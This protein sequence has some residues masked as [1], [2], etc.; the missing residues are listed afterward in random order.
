LQ[1]S[2]LA[3]LLGIEQP[4]L[5][6]QIVSLFHLPYFLGCV[7]LSAVMGPAGILLAD[8]MDTG[9]MSYAVSDILSPYSGHPGWIGLL[10]L[11]LVAFITFWLLYMIRFMRLRLARAGPQLIS[12]SPKTEMTRKIFGIVSKAWPQILVTAVLFGSTQIFLVLVTGTSSSNITSGYFGLGSPLS[13][14]IEL[15][16]YL[17]IGTFVWVYA[18]ALWGIHRFGKEPL[19]LKPFYQDPLLGLGEMGTLSLYLA[20]AYYTVFGPVMFESLFLSPDP[21]GYATLIPFVVLGGIMF[22]LPLN[23]IHQKMVKV[24][25]RETENIEQK[26]ADILTILHNPAHIPDG[27]ASSSQ[28]ENL[29][30]VEMLQVT[31]RSLDQ[32][33]SWPYDKATFERFTALVLSVASVLISQLAQKYIRGP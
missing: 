15:L 31:Q 28:I 9:N 13:Y 12:L 30:K 5:V 3:H 20:F 7:V 1:P 2:S 29:L 21:V 24:K 32:V 10:D 4:T 6:E 23:S 18:S 25:K 19:R 22:F 33:P 17:T 14:L 16:F 8:Y 26:L 27:A 11:S